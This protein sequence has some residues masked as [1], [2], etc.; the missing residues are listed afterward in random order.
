M[1]EAANGK[2]DAKRT[3]LEGTGLP[4][5]GGSHGNL[6]SASNDQQLRQI[7]DSLKSSKSPVSSIAPLQS[8][9]NHQMDQTVSRSIL[10]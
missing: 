4:L 1:A 5:Q 10:L 6:H 3:G 7:L 2:H 8:R 9:L